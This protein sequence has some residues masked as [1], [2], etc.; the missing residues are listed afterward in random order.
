MA[1]IQILRTSRKYLSLLGRKKESSQGKENKA[2]FD[3]W[4]GFVFGKG[5]ENRTLLVAARWKV[6]PTFCA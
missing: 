1:T 5:K 6:W 3:R 2:F 4:G